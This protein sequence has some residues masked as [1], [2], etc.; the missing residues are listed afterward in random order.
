MSTKHSEW[1][2]EVERYNALTAWLEVKF[3]SVDE[4]FDRLE[5]HLDGKF[6]DIGERFDR[7][8]IDIHELRG[9]VKAILNRLDSIESKLK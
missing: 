1:T 9:D 2:P 5:E 4:R 6:R 8:E 7:V 3:G